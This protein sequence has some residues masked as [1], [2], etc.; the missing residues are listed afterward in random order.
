MRRWHN[1]RQE[2]I[3]DPRVDAYLEALVQL[4][5]THGFILSHEDQHGSFIV[6]D[7]DNNEVSVHEH[8]LL[9]AMSDVDEGVK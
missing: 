8:W 7:R 5:R 6:K 9:N 2:K 4:G 1:K 3:E